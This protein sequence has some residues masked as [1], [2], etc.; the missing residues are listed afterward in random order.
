MNNFNLIKK[1]LEKEFEWFTKQY[2]MTYFQDIRLRIFPIGKN[3]SETWGEEKNGYLLY[4]HDEPQNGCDIILVLNTDILHDD[5]D[6]MMISKY[7]LGPTYELYFFMLYHELGHLMDLEKAYEDQGSLGISR[8]LHQYQREVE[9]V[10][11]EYR[12]GKLKDREIS[13]MYRNLVFEKFADE[14]AS[15]I[16]HKRIS[17]I[18]EYIHEMGVSNYE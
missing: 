4:E 10:E 11:E 13:M 7:Q 9:C 8:K 14:F 5:I 12:I 17:F 15:K 18:R 16:Y 2:E 1:G 3:E 6:R